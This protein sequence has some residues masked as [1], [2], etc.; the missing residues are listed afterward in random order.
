[1][2]IPREL[3][4]RERSRHDFMTT[5][6]QPRTLHCCFLPADVGIHANCYANM[7]SWKIIS[8]KYSRNFKEIGTGI[9][10][11]RHFQLNLIDMQVFQ[12]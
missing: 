1:M 10:L 8:L 6:F 12:E 9:Y 7:T 4:H 3:R 5:I 11:D 2:R